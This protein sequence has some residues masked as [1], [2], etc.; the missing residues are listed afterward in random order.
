LTASVKL[1]LQNPNNGH[2]LVKKVLKMITEESENPDLR[3]RGIF[4]IKV[5]FTG[6]CL[7]LILNKLE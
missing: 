4:R 5:L 1:F 7:I 3:D 2:E 6:D